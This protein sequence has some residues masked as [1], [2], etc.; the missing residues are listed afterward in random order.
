MLDALLQTWALVD[1]ALGTDT[2]YLRRLEKVAEQ[3]RLTK[4]SYPPF[5]RTDLRLVNDY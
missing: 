2:N 5:L 1:L 3:E 4:P